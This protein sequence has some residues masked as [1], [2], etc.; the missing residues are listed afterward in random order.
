MRIYRNGA[1]AV[2]SALHELLT[3]AAPPVAE[4]TVDQGLRAHPKWGARDRHFFADAVYEILRWR[5]LLGAAAGADTAWP[6]LAAHLVRRGAETLPDWSEFAGLS[7][8]TMAAR[9]ADPALPLAVR[10]SMPDWLAAY[11]SAENAPNLLARW[12]AELAAQNTAA[13]V[14]L[15]VNPLKGTVAQAAA[16]LLAEGIETDPVPGLPWALRLRVRKPVTRTAAFQAG[17]VELQD[18]GSQRIAPLLAVEPGMR[19][20]DGCAGAG[21]KTLHLAGLLRNRGEIR[22][23]DIVDNRLAELRRRATRAGATN[24]ETGR[25]DDAATRAALAN[26]A[27]RLLLDVPCTG[28]GTL[29]RQPDLKWRLTPAFRAEVGAAQ[30]QILRDYPAMLRP[31]GLLVYATCSLLPAEGEDVIREQL[32]APGN[33]LELLEEHRTW[34]SE[35]ADDGFYMALLHKADGPV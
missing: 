4:R 1:E 11:P 7:V 32:A 33:A 28:T 27:D 17:L 14:T 8:E 21:G 18:G 16:R 12:P 2:V 34:T 20:L 6:L 35:T 5:R 31:G 29:R 10:E 25:A 15:R 13:P 24:I 22:A 23:L 30:R 19:V 9:L 26:W 3:A